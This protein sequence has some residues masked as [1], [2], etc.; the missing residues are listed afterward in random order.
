MALVEGDLR[1]M[2]AAERTALNLVQRACGIATR[3]SQFVD[4][5]DGSGVAILD[6]FFIVYYFLKW[7]NFMKLAQKIENDC[8]PYKMAHL[9]LHLL[10]YLRG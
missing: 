4:A 8:A 5:V 9:Q 3:T 10:Q 2:L 1:A 6:N 7:L